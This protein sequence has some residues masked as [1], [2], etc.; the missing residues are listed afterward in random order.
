MNFPKITDLDINSTSFGTFID[1]M[2]HSNDPW[3]IKDHESRFIYM[4]G[5]GNYYSSLPRDYDVEGKL[6]SECPTYLSEFSEVLQANDKLVM[7]SQK[8]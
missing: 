5:N 4:N 1:Y 6:D 3:F 2:K 8:V 7:G